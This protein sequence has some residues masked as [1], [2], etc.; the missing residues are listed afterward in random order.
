[1]SAADSAPPAGNEE[2]KKIMETYAGRGT[3]SD[4]TKPLPPAEALKTFTVREGLTI[5][6]V[7]AEPAV[8]QPLFMSFDSKGQLWVTQYIQYQY[9]AGLKVVSFDQHL[10]AVFDKV[11]EPPPRGV[12]GAD[13]ITVF[14]DKDG[15]GTYESHRDV[16]TGLNIATAAVKGGG[17]IWVLNPPYLLFYPD[18]NDDDLPDGDPKVCL[19]GFG[20]EDT[21]SVAS[22]LIL[23]PDGW[24]YGATGSTTTGNVSSRVSKNV[25]FVG[26]HI[27]RYHPK[28]EVFEIFAEGGGNTFSSEIDAQ[29][30][31][32]SGTN[33]A[34][35]GMH[36]DQGMSGVKGFGKH[37]TPGNPYAFG[38]FEHMTTKSDGK[39]FS[40]AFC[41]Y[42]GDLMAK[43]LGGRIIAP[44]SLHNMVYVS[45]RIPDGSTFR[46]EDDPPLVTSRD[47][48]FR[49]VDAKVGPDGAVYL[50][51][52]YDTRL[53]HVRPIDDWS[54]TDGR[55]YRIRPATASMKREP[56]DLHTATPLVLLKYLNHENRWFRRQ[57]ALE[58][59]W[60][61]ETRSLPALEALARDKA[62]VHAFDAL[63]AIEM[64]G[65]MRDELASELLRHPDP[66]VR[67]W[68]VRSAGD[69]GD[70]SPALAS[71]LQ[72]LAAREQHPEVRTQLL[73]TAKRLPLAPCLALAR[74]MM[75]RDADQSDKRLPLLLW[76]ALES[77][78]EVD[79]GALLALFKDAALWRHPVA[80]SHGIH[81]L[82]QRWAMAG[83]RENFEACT[84]LLDLAPQPAD[85]TLVIEG[86]ADAFEGGK[87]PELPPALATALNTH[88]A[89]KLDTNLALAVKSGNAEA[90]KKALAVI[91]DDKAPTAN[92][93]ALAQAFADAGNRE[94]IPA[95]MQIFTRAG[96]PT[97]RQA[98]LPIAAKFPDQDL[99]LA[100]IKGYEARFSQTAPLKDGTHRMLAS[101]R[102]WAQLFLEEIDR[103]LIRARDVAPDVVRQMELYRDPALDRLIQKNFP[104]SGGKL[105]S[106]EKIAELKRMKGV[107]AGGRG[108]AM[109][110]KVLFTQKCAACHILF[111]EGG[112]IGPNLTGYERT[113]PDFWLVGV[114][115][116][117]AEIR[118]G[119]NA[120]LAQ[121]KG[122][123]T[124]MGMIV[125]QDAGTVVL[126]DMAGQKHAARTSEIEKL[127]VFPQSLM[128]EGLLNG[129]DDAAL[130]DLF[131]Y[132]SK[133]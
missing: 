112:Q 44:N 77:K 107:L 21:H 8:T 70:V 128:P 91:R 3:L 28:T 69:D 17:G 23:G 104:N 106:Q 46:I 109:K 9:P 110:G 119:Y 29:G 97:V 2:V 6:L 63:C 64:L 60:R 73:A 133:P 124:L 74:V 43:E 86:M 26:Q 35:R 129:V 59:G 27:W 90:A 98:L 93:V 11:P 55:I 50:A 31:V 96:N 83:G 121:L 39:R 89:S 42:D 49:P 101:R 47:R 122:G 116:P 40:Q 127:D 114:L 88:L 81:H 56:F 65:G 79:R 130:R 57:A 45:R 108:D 10:R 53:S 67:R 76:W 87:I 34:Q 38:Y 84:K 37:G 131:A 54:K 51:D 1:M 12:K 113:S 18:A 75:E 115:D 82:A 117:S 22:S 111:D 100:V 25:R 41:I 80:R 58:L 99:A 30:R 120:Y 71:A 85:R 95:I 19:S 78:S 72:E 24:V 14:T 48:W 105:S 61:N 118:E 94:V 33:A 20:L 126:K 5:D 132:L 102:E 52:W 15:D 62:N 13:K 125:Q 32:F 103:W 123:Q 4:G 36:Y 92:R 16:I 68:V 7:A 66:Y